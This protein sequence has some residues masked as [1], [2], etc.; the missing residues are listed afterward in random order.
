[1]PK[2]TERTA[3]I[4][5]LTAACSVI[6]G[7][8]AQPPGTLAATEEQVALGQELYQG[9]TRLTGGGPACNT[10][11]EVANDSVIGGGTLARE[12]TDAYS[13]LGES[14]LVVMIETAPYPAMQRAY[15]DRPPTETEIAA[16][17]GFLK[18]ADAEK[19][20]HQARPYAPLMLGA[21]AVGSTLLLG[22][23]TLIW[24]RRKRDSVNQEIYDRQTKSA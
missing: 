5:V 19:A 8:L 20:E 23:Y 24:S 16:L 12:L 10:C 2:L 1:M 13:R 15:R 11:H 14:A 3:L 4:P 21:G 17:V 22:L 9:T 18:S 6:A 7:W